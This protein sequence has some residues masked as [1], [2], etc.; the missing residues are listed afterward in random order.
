MNHNFT[1]LFTLLIILSLSACTNNTTKST[2]SKTIHT[3][4][5]K[6]TSTETGTVLAV[7]SMTIKPE[8]LRPRVGVS[9]GS[10]GY[11]GVHGGFD[12]GN[13][14]R[15]LQDSN[16][17]KYEQ[18][19]VVRKNNGDTVSIT[20]ITREHFKKGDQ[21]KLIVLRTGEARVVH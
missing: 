9:F 7:K 4:L 16:K 11:R 5:N 3:Q 21:V 13:V 6:Q 17:P 8:K 19:I 2:T 18:E 14:V 10:G 1:L 15:A 20:Q 12:I